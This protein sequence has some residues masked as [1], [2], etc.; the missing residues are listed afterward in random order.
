M[1]KCLER[2]VKLKEWQDSYRSL[3]PSAETYSRYYVNT[4]AEGGSRIDRCY[5]FGGLKVKEAKYLPL[6]FSDHFAH[7]VQFILPDQHSKVLSPKSRPSFRLRAEVLKDSV[8]K[9]RLEESMKSWQ[10]V[11]QFQS[12]DSREIGTLY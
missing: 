2:L 6:A 1:S 7:V 8:F 12:E 9:Y 4:R 10:R 3:H 5:H 11:R